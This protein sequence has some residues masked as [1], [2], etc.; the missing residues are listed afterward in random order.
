MAN[1][2]KNYPTADIGVAASTVYTVPASTTAIIIGLWVSNILA[3]SITVDVYVTIGGVDYYLVKAAPIP[4][5]GA[6]LP[7]GA[8][9]KNVLETGD[10]LKIA[11]SEATAADAVL[12]CLEIT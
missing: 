12:S 9:S 7:I 10:A 4:V 1:T 2:F 3:N 11:A 8:G 5:G 6:L